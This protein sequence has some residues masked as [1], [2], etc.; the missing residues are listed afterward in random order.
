MTTPKWIE[1]KADTYSGL[2]VWMDTTGKNSHEFHE[3]ISK[4]SYIAGAMEVY[5]ELEKW[6]NAAFIMYEDLKYG[7]S[8]DAVKD[9]VAMYERLKATEK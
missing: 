8:I 1:E 7:A 9:S 6:K 4:E 5:Q 2:Q 3:Y